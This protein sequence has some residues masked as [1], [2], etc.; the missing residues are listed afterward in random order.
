[1]LVEWALSMV[2]PI[3]KGK[4]DISNSIYYR[5]VKLLGME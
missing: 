2:F 4:G 5:A 1:M 3:F